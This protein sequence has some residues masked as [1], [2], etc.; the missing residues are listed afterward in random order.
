MGFEWQKF[1][2]FL[3]PRNRVHQLSNVQGNQPARLLCVNY[4][5]LAMATVGEPGF[6]FNSPY[7]GYGYSLDGDSY[8]QAK[9][10]RLASGPGGGITWYGNFFPSMRAWDHLAEN[11][12]R[13]AGGEAVWIRFPRSGM[14][15]HMSV[16]AA[17]T[18]KKA[19]RHGPGYVIVVPSGEG[20]SILWPEG[21]E[22]VVVPWH[23]ASIFVPPD[24]WF[25]Q[26]FNLGA[27]PARYLALHPPMGIGFSETIRTPARDQIEYPDEDPVIRQRF[28][29]ELRKR[30]LTSLM[31][32]EA[33][34]DRKYRWAVGS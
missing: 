17:R 20:Y 21:G 26:H 19:H 14:A 34:R 23:E 32:E 4:L 6:F 25:H 11:E 2:M 22:K 5:P 24:Q 9:E 16:F 30:G 31:R 3:I 27:E 8:S 15:C 10:V 33:Y 7:E 18:Y 12:D 28:E 1:S 13:G 29:E